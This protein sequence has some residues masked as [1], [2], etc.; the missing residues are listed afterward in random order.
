MFIKKHFNK[1]KKIIKS[2]LEK[3]IFKYTY[4]LSADVLDEKDRPHTPPFIVTGIYRSGTTLVTSFLEALGVDLGPE[5]HKFQN[6]GRLAALDLNP[7]GF[8]E[9]FLINDLGRY[10]LQYAGGSGVEFPSFK[11]LGALSLSAFDNVDFA[12][13]AIKV[14]NDDRVDGQIRRQILNHYNISNINQYFY[15]H[16]DTNLWG[17]KDVHSGAYMPIYLKKW[18]NAKW[19]CVFREP[20]SFLKSANMGSGMSIFPELLQQVSRLNWE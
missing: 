18:H 17:F 5:E 20:S 11:K 6:V 8:Q 3:F 10:I 4:R 13:Y 9:N 15:D 19:I 1:R 12:Y 7:D 2:V 16:F 14:L